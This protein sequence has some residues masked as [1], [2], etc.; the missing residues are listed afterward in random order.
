MKTQ[1]FSSISFSETLQNMD[2]YYY[3]TLTKS[4]V[5]YG[6]AQLPMTFVTSSTILAIL[7]LIKKLKILPRSS[8]T[9]VFWHSGALQIGLL[10]L[11]PQPYPKLLSS[12]F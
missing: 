4:H 2:R 10:L 8:A 3:E 9:E 1:S 12:P 7:F 5:I 11:F 6:T